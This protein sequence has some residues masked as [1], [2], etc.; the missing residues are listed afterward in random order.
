MNFKEWYDDFWGTLTYD[1]HEAASKI[2]WKACKE[3]ILKILKENNKSVSD[4][5]RDK[6]IVDMSL[7]VEKIEKL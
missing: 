5:I 7:L 3:E 4:M 2:A 1:H 6:F